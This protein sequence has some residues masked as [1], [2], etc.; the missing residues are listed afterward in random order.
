MALALGGVLVAAS[1][2]F[3]QLRHQLFHIGQVVQRLAGASA[4]GAAVCAGQDNL[5]SGVDEVDAALVALLVLVDQF[6]HGIDGQAD[7]GG[8]DE[9]VLIIEHL[10]VDEHGHLVLVGHV[11]VDVD[12]VG[13]GHVAHAEIP[14]VA[15]LLWLDLLEHALGLVVG[16][17]D[18][19]DEESGV[20]AVM[21]HDF[22]QV[23]GH[24][25]GVAF[26]GHHPVA[27]EGI[28]RHHR[29][30]QDRPHQV[31]LDF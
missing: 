20:G 22:A 18:I 1:G 26:A 27:H 13:F 30:D 9:F 11:Q 4:V 17:A 3:G 5:A 6:D 12:L 7:T 19:G 15:R 29:G 24:L 8:T 28:A 16:Q 14:D 10:V 23:A 2:R 21:V 31:F 25:V